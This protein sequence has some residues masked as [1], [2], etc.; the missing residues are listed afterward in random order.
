[1]RPR[2]YHAHIHE[3]APGAWLVGFYDV[4]EAIAQGDTLAEAR[5]N[6]PDAL[7]AA[8]EGYLEL[9]RTLPTPAAIDARQAAT[10]YTIVEVA[11]DPHIAARALLAKAMQDQGLSK[12][13][14]AQRMGR[15]EKV[16]RRIL[17]GQG[18]SLDLVLE[19]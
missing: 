17:A 18:A 1:M 9:G 7:A 6:A 4:P 11:L 10:G 8:L 3:A 2:T 13:A 19:A 15:D 5:E 16:A 12:V 14:L